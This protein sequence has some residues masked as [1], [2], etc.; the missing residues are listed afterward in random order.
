MNICLYILCIFVVLRYSN[1]CTQKITKICFFSFFLIHIYKRFC[2]SCFIRLRTYMSNLRRKKK[3][4]KKTTYLTTI[5]LNTVCGFFFFFFSLKQW[6]GNFSTTAPSWF[7]MYE[8][9]DNCNILNIFLLEFFFFE[10][11]RNSNVTVNLK[12]NN[13]PSP[14]Y[15][16]ITLTY[17]LSQ[18]IMICRLCFIA[19]IYRSFSEGIKDNLI[20]SNFISKKSGNSDKALFWFLLSWLGR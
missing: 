3:K 8:D 2:P 5:S 16:K 6:K 7:S 13:P 11:S 12:I 18:L 19:W 9:W 1:F 14:W 17:I 10:L 20:K 15:L 4:Q